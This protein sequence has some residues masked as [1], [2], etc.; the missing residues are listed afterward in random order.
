MVCLVLANNLPK[1]DPYRYGKR[2]ARQ[3]DSNGRLCGQHRR[4]KTKQAESGQTVSYSHDTSLGGG[5]VSSSFEEYA[6][7]PEV[8]T[9]A[10]GR[11]LGV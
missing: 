7:V 6:G 3:L 9:T 1:C 4:Q 11:E 2:G 10:F 5:K 8:A